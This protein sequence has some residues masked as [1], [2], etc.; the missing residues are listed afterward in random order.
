MCSIYVKITGIQGIPYSTSVYI[1]QAM[2]PE[3]VIYLWLVLHVHVTIVPYK[4]THLNSVRVFFFSCLSGLIPKVEKQKEQRT[5]TQQTK[6]LATQV[7]LILRL[8]NYI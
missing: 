7:S 5:T 2:I 1:S 6:V 8:F 3:G 4:V